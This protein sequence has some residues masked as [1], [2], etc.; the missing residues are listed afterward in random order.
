MNKE[1]KKLYSPADK[2]IYEGF[3]VADKPFGAITEVCQSND[4]DKVIKLKEKT[5]K[6]CGDGVVNTKD[7]LNSG[8]L[9][10]NL[11][12]LREEEDNL[13]AG[14]KFISEHPQY[15]LL[16]QD[17]LNYC[18]ST[19]YLKLPVK[20]NRFVLY[21]RR[22]NDWTI[23]ENIYHYA[24]SRICFVMDSRDPYNQLFMKYFIKTPWIDADTQIALSGGLPSG[25][26]Y[27]VSVIIPLYNMEEYIGE[28]LDSLLAQ[29]FQAFEIIVVDDCS[30]DSSCAI[31]ESYAPKFNGR[32]KLTHTKK[33]SGGGGYVPRNIGLSLARGEYVYF[34]DA[35]DMI[36]GTALETFYAATAFFDVDV[37][38]ASSYYGLNAPDDVSFVKDALGWRLPGTNIELTVDDPNKNLNRL[39]FESEGGNF[40]TPWTRFVRRDFLIKNQI[41]FPLISS[42]GDFLWVI[43]VYCQARRFLRISTPLCLHRKYNTNS[44]TRKI[45]EPQEQCWYWFCSLLDFAKAFNKLEKNNEI[46]SEN[47][48]YRF[49]AFK[50][51][52]RWCLNQTDYARKEIDSEELFKVLH[53]E[54][55][56]NFSDSSALLL[57]FLFSFI[58]EEK[59]DN[60]YY[61]ELINKF[62]SYIT[63]R[64]DV[65]F[66]SSNGDFQ[67][68]FISDGKANIRKATWLPK[69]NIGY[70]IQSYAGKLEF[71][72]KTT[73]TG[74]VDVSLR[75][76]D[77]RDPEDKSKRIPY[78][79][80]YT[81]LTVNGK[82]MFDNITPAWHDKPYRY[83]MNVKAD[84]EITLE[85]EWLPHRSDTVEIGTGN[86]Y[87]SPLLIAEANEPYSEQTPL[88][89]KIISSQNPLVHPAVSVIISMYN[90]EKYIAECLDSLLVQT[91]K[92]FEVLI[93]D[94]CSTD[95]SI[96]I[97]ENYAQKFEGRF[98][99]CKTKKNSG[100]GGEPRNIGFSL[101]S[102]EYVF[103]VDSDDVITKTALEEMYSLAREYSADVVYC[104]KYFMSEGVGKDFIANTHP[105]SE[106]IQK[107]PFVDK[108]T[109][110]TTNMVER[111]KR[112]VNLNYW[113]TPWLRMVQRSLLIENRIKFDSLIGSNDIGW[114]FR[115]LFCS[116]RFLRVPN[117]CYIRRVHDGST[118]FRKRTP[119]GYVHKWMDLPVRA[120]KNIDNFMNGI[121]FFRN[122]LRC[123][124]E[125]I[126][127][128]LRTS[129]SNSMKECK[130]LQRAEVFNNF[131]QAFSEYLGRD[132]VLVSAFYAYVY[133]IR[134]N[135][136]YVRVTNKLA[137]YVTS[138]IDLKLMT[139]TGD[140]QIISISDYTADVSQPPWFQKNG[141]GYVIQSYVGKL[142]IIAKATVDG[143]V[144]LALK[145]KYVPK[146]NDKSKRIP[147]WIDYTSLTING[148]K[149]ISEITPAWHDKSFDYKMDVEAD[150]EIV[151]E[152][153][154]LP[155]RS[156]TVAIAAPAP[157]KVA[158]TKKLNAAIESLSTKTTE[159][160]RYNADLTQ[161]V[162]SLSMK[163]T[164]LQR[165]NSDLAQ[166][167]NKFAPYFTARIDVKLVTST[168]DFQILS[169][170]DESAEVS[171]PAWF[172]K[173]GIGYAITSHVGNLKITAKA[174]ADGQIQ[175]YLRSRDIRDP[176]DRSKHIPQWIDYTELTVNGLTILNELTPAWHDKPY[177]YNVEVKADEEI[178]IEV[179]WLPHTSEA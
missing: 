42:S 157:E 142:K 85:V 4:R 6:I 169:L 176:E 63:A 164:E 173:D 79:I 14:M 81:K 110:E 153:E 148:Q 139:N 136:D 128:F 75:G 120:L 45:R 118:S 127:Y 10:M 149:I 7:Y 60:S 27:P 124:H 133:D 54:L 154:W 130:G 26:N 29:T 98:W 19:K 119:G 175:L 140:F 151:V 18:F 50:K 31:V 71:V 13:S 36:L 135:G 100:G 78:W 111:V 101:A 150:E 37:V 67:I 96:K 104:E 156:D 161:T 52:L 34:L 86:S 66:M 177:R 76:I 117:A 62:K 108:P 48:A 102:G 72:A 132:A 69:N 46:L 147:Y 116:K 95:N 159:L 138:R 80:D 38:Y 170:S 112:A 99:L 155:H 39:L 162:E 137:P 122:N 106:R 125:V 20:F 103:F 15:D 64:I 23:G 141:V 113:V 166:I 51:H 114:S 123:R 58:D 5:K 9:L 77:F 115:V 8:V 179:E 47:Y 44:I 12:V 121:E 178:T 94:D 41:S 40:H 144:Q 97:A 53:S 82:T 163:T 152:V 129:L 174:V 74:K 165:N 61:I 171:K 3:I 91:F 57:P 92:D 160:Q 167:I 21:A 11:K 32:L 73:A 146:G 87:Q 107:P 16:D 22:K 93:T 109:I 30:T 59:K 88:F 145:G 65:K 134:Y 2:L 24:A 131:L 33:N 84:E 68:I 105:A 17:I 126:N 55:A 28:C 172:N 83:S 25:K 168:G 89:E 70:W 43:N 49:G 143:I 90:A 1:W 158:E 56:Q 35:D